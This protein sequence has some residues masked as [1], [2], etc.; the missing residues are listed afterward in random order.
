[1][2]GIAC[3]AGDFGAACVELLMP[4]LGMEG[5]NLPQLDRVRTGRRRR[6]HVAHNAL[7]DRLVVLSTRLQFFGRIDVLAAVLST[8]CA[9]A[10]S[11]PAFMWTLPLIISFGFRAD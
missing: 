7:T 10:G 2:R 9:K 6:Q 5:L 8:R 1:M 11:N 4:N 3:K